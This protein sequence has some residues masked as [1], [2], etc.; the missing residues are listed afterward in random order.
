MDL[1]NYV[2]LAVE[3]N[4]VSNKFGLDIF[5]TAFK[6]AAKCAGVETGIPN[7]ERDNKFVLLKENFY[8]AMQFLATAIFAHEGNGAFEAMFS[9]MLVEKIV[10][11]DKQCKSVVFWRASSALLARSRGV[12]SNQ[13][14]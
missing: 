3:R 10:T 13:G 11:H 5:Y 2:L 4:M 9:H 8:L 1:T 14:I 7:S 12:K 6:E